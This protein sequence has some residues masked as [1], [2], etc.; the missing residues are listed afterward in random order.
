MFSG[1]DLS[2]ELSRKEK[3]M[4]TE[5]P[6]VASV[7]PPQVHQELLEMQGA[8]DELIEA[9]GAMTNRLS[10]ALRESEPPRNNVEE[11]ISVPI[12]P[13]ASAIRVQRGLVRQAANLIGDLLRRLEL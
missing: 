7:N 9:L 5:S 6:A 1:Y 3:Q 8:L 13:L 11:K 4:R 10:P 12:V 2:E